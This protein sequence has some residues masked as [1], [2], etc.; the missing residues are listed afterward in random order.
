MEERK[1]VAVEL[2]RD[3]S[4]EN[5]EALIQMANGVKRYVKS[6]ITMPVGIDS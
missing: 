1:A 2:A 6:W 3:G 5:V 4:D